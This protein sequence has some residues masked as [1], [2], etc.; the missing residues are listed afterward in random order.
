MGNALSDLKICGLR[1]VGLKTLFQGDGVT[2]DS[3]VRLVIG[4]VLILR[5]LKR[6]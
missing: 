5:P 1:R 3:G 2:M 6:T 4:L